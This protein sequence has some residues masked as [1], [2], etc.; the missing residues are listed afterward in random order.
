MTCWKNSKVLLVRVL[1]QLDGAALLVS[2][3]QPRAA[4][5]MLYS[6]LEDTRAVVGELADCL[7]EARGAGAPHTTPQG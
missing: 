2:A 6:A 7:M 5:E 3:G 1:D 4:A